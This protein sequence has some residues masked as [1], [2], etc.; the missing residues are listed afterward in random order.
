MGNAKENVGAVV[1]GG[2]AIYGALVGA[3]T[4]PTTDDLSDANDKY[5]QSRE[6]SEGEYRGYNDKGN[7]QK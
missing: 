6:T 5:T 7:S 2:S 4:P 1:I 3:G